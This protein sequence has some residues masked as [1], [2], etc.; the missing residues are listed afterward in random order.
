MNSHKIS[1]SDIPE[2]IK[3]VTETLEK[4]GFEAYLVGGC[5]RDMLLNKSPKDWDITTNATPEQIIEL[6]PETFYENKFGTVGVVNE[7]VTDETLKIVEVT[8]YRIEGKYSDNR[9]PDEVTFSTKLED[10]LQ[11]R[12]FT[13]NAFA[14]SVSGET[15]IDLYNGMED[16]RAG[17]LHTVGDPVERFN[18]DGL[19]ILRAVRLHTELGFT[20]N[21]ETEKAIQDNASLLENIAQERIRDEF[22]RI[23]MSDNPEE[24]LKTALKLGILPYIAPELLEGDGVEQTATHAFDVLTHLLKTLQHAAKKEYPVHLRLAALFH[25]I[26]K[27]ATRRMGESK[28]TFYGHEVV[29]ARMTKKI[30]ERL[31]FSRE[32]TESVV[33]LVRWHMFFADTE[34]ITH[35]AVRRLITKVGKDHIWDLMNLRACDRIGTGRPKEQPYRLRKYKAMV[36]EVMSDPVSVGMLKI[37]GDILIA[38]Y[39]MKPGKEIGYILHALLEEV[40]DDPVKNT[41][42]HLGKRAI[43]LS[44]LPTEELQTLGEAGKETREKEEEKQIKEI[45]GKYWVE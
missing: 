13:I 32:L 30:M 38:E 9:R 12:D 44:K 17:E 42:E 39:K 14:Y 40:L 35:S 41:E 29:G 37:N 36:E 43:E 16:L 27:P 45:R 4:G 26:A 34:Q 23:V 28:Y 18:E 6:F 21:G 25:D 19:R 22:V 10:D 33:N 1:L 3:N 24:G 15:L 20:I 31:K 8:P 5:V 2:E 11:R 7:E